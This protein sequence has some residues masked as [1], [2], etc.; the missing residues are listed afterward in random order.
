VP[1]LLSDTEIRR[2][3]GTVILD[4]D[5]T[6]IRPNAYVMRLGAKG[7]FLN[8]GKD[9]DIGHGKRGLRIQPGHSVGVTAFETLD[10]SRETVHKIYP[11]EDLHAIVSPT[12]DLSREGVVAPTTAVDAGFKGTLNWTFTNTASEERK[13]VFKERIYR[14]TIYRLKE[15]ERPEGLY[16]RETIKN[17]QDMSVQEEA[18][19]PVGMKDAEFE[20]GLVEGGP[21]AILDNLIRSGYPWNILG[22]RLRAIDQ[23]F[24]NVTDEYADIVESIRTLTG[25]LNEIRTKQNST[26]DIVRGVLKEEASALQNRWLIA[27]V[28]MLGGFVGLILAAASNP[29]VAQFVKEQGSILGLGL[30][31][32]AV[33]ALVLISR[34]TQ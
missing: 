19:P 27:T 31:V 18:A 20:D 34:K 28:A 2:L 10:S 14:I 11:D 6:C 25:H 32:V 5:P 24:K 16:T 1:I 29:T 8:T 33:I 3:I 30:I 12:T 13:F 9:F 23:Q 22:S 21:E 15:G 4:G 17:K 26:P 7:E